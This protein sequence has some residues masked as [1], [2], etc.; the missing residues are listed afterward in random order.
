M[1]KSTQL[2]W[3]Y[4]L[5]DRMRHGL[6]TALIIV[7]CIGSSFQMARLEAG[8]TPQKTKKGT[9]LIA[10][11]V[12]V[13]ILSAHGRKLNDAALF[14][15]TTPGYMLSRRL[16]ADS[17]ESGKP[18]PIGLITFEGPAVKDIDVL[19]EFPSGRFLSHWPTARLQSRRI[20]WRSQNLLK[21]SQP[22]MQLADQH[23]LRHL[24]SADRLFLQGFDKTE[25]FILYDIELMHTPRITLSRSKDGF[26][27]QNGES[28][29]LRHVTILQPSTSKEGWSLAAIDKVAGIK[30][31][32]KTA[33]SKSTKTTKS[34]LPDPLSEENLLKRA[35][36]QKTNQLTAL[37][38]KLR[39]IGALPKLSPSTTKAKPKS[40]TPV[41]KNI[42]PVEIPFTE[43]T[44]LAQDKILAIWEKKLVDL[45]L[46]RPETNHV[47]K[48]LGQHA[49]R[50][51]QATVVF[52][53]DEGYLDK[54]MPLE[55]TPFPDVI[56]RTAIVILVDADPA[57]LQRIDR[58]IA[59][60]GNAS[61]DKREAAQKE[62]EKYGKAAQAQLKKATKNKDLEIVFRAEQI[63]E[64]IK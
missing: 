13:F 60:L 51:D 15:S 29:P 49:L 32:K 14:R 46:G 6:R 43:K 8:E 30:K 39:E 40:A 17:S 52:S 20:Y 44:P 54:I 26:Q 31:E 25:R 3:K 9:Q 59:Q 63:L 11:D 10:R 48:I 37:G 56:R 57:L 62:L 34:K 42:P 53:L 47:L 55:I 28:F 2:Q 33:T 64:N 58:L 24:Q 36:A 50:K 19:I 41:K 21:A 27:I 38:N 5:H 7:C 4:Q 35:K 23:W 18:T 45:G 1:K 22:S 16:S 61:W 12:N